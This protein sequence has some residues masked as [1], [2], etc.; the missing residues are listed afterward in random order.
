MKKFIYSFL[1]LAAFLIL[2]VFLW[3]GLYLNPQTLE[4]SLIGKPLPPFR[5]PVF[6]RG[7]FFSDAGFKGQVSLLNVWASWCPAC[8]QEQVVLLALARE[9]IAVYGLNY[10]DDKSSAQA[11]LKEW[12]N[13]YRKILIDKEGRTAINLGVYGA[14]ETFVIDKKGIIRYRYA[15]ILS[16]S[17]WQKEIKP[18]M[19]SLEKAL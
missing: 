3:R 6:E 7:Q 18:L 10:K 14:P 13:P 12:G 8:Q 4:S 9:G 19:I 1:P 5:L 16:D 11:W 15:G 2:A 17:V